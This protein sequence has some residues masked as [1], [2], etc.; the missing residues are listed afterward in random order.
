M[1]N[2]TGAIAKPAR[3][4]PTRN[5]LPH[6]IWHYLC[7]N[8]LAPPALLALAAASPVLR[9]IVRAVPG[10][11]RVLQNIVC[12]VAA[13]KDRRNL[14]EST[15]QDIREEYGAEHFDASERVY[16]GAEE[17]LEHKHP[18]GAEEERCNLREMP[19]SSWRVVPVL[20]F[21]LWLA[22]SS[23]TSQSISTS[24]GAGRTAKSETRMKES[25]DND[26]KLA[27]DAVCQVNRL[28]SD[29]AFRELCG[30]NRPLSPFTTS[31]AFV[32]LDIQ[33]LRFVHRNSPEDLASFRRGASPSGGRM[34]ESVPLA[35]SVMNAIKL[36][37]CPYLTTRIIFATVRDIAAAAADRA[38]TAER[39]RKALIDAASARSFTVPTMY[40]H[41]SE[42]LVMFARADTSSCTADEIH[43]V[44][45]RELNIALARLQ[46]DQVVIC[47]D[48]R[49]ENLR[50]G[51]LKRGLKLHPQSFLARSFIRGDG[52]ALSLEQTVDEIA[53]L[54]YLVEHTE[55]AARKSVAIAAGGMHLFMAPSVSSRQFS[56]DDAFDQTVEAKLI[57]MRCL[58]SP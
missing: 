35:R 55:Y 53:R 16:S 51:L 1:S 24:M 13:V 22:S 18:C 33:R 52:D 2:R 44:G 57:Q 5:S 26:N 56:H 37:P 7:T 3:R 28:L 9:E 4:R 29:T 25:Q 15:R 50:S 32:P 47:E 38:E 23:N 54:T 48:M 27:F 45:P 8:H 49:E 21:P 46:R 11:S 42:S 36:D 41:C 31:P 20:K 40:R 34:L 14:D 6:D 10:W 19:T 39:R 43:V 12:D 30:P 58:A 17:G